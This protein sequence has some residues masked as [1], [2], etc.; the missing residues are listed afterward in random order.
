M[1]FN[2]KADRQLSAHSGQRLTF[3]FAPN[4]AVPSV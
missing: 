3:R 1:N 4:L 2:L